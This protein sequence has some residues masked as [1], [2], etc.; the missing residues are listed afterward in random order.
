MPPTPITDILFRGRFEPGALALAAHA[1]AADNDEFGDDETRAA[2]PASAPTGGTTLT[3]VFSRFDAWYEI[4]SWLEGQFL[5][6]TVKGAFKKTIK[7]NRDGMVVAYDHGYDPEIGDKPLGPIEDLRETDEGPFYLVPLLATSYNS[8]FVLPALQGLTLDGRSFGST[9]GASFR[10]RV[11]RDEWVMAPKP[12]DYNPKGIPERTIRE[13]RVFEFGPVPYPAS[14]A[15][16]AGVR[17][18]TDWYHDRHRARSG[19]PRSSTPAGPATG[20][21]STPTPPLDGHLVDTSRSATA[22][23][24]M[25]AKARRSR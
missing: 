21:E 20:D 11:L 10:F 24:A 6:R 17:G 9:L 22:Y 2:A 18:L 25:V 7:E 12:S 14:A 23:L 3:G 8:E 15:A 19:G 13:A 5:E 1:P 16:S 4:D